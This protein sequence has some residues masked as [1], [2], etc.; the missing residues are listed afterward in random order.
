MARQINLYRVNRD[1]NRS[2]MVG[3]LMGDVRAADS[4]TS[5]TDAIRRSIVVAIDLKPGQ[6]FLFWVSEEEED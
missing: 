1:A 6:G 4:D 2:D 5:L 3:D